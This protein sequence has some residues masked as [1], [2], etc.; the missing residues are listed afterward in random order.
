MRLCSPSLLGAVGG[1]LAGIL[2]QLGSGCS[3]ALVAPRYSSE[4][5]PVTVA[6]DGAGSKYKVL[7]LGL[8]LSRKISI[9]DEPH[10]PENVKVRNVCNV[11]TGRYRFCVL[12]D[13]TV[14]TVETLNGIPGADDE[15]AKVLKS[16]R[17]QPARSAVC[18][19][20][21]LDFDIPGRGKLCDQPKSVQRYWLDERR[22][23]SEVP[24]VPGL[25][26]PSSAVGKTLIYKFCVGKDGTV[27]S[28]IPIVGLA[29]ADIRIE[30]AI[31]RWRYSPLPFVACAFE[32]LKVKRDEF[33]I[34][35]I[36][37][38]LIMNREDAVPL[39]LNWDVPG[40][41]NS[42]NMLAAKRL[43]SEK[44]SGEDPHLPDAVRA[45]SSGSVVT[46]AYKLCVAMDGSI[47]GID[48]ASSIEGADEQIVATLSEWHYKAQPR[49]GCFIQFFEFE[50]I[51]N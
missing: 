43:C 11:L 28:A 16:W 35:S 50:I 34:P 14:D 25:A 42:P 22:L 31:K 37:P 13:G 33:G 15:I 2:L 44:V 21:S 10:L 41:N 12:P 24:R 5:G 46:G 7:P 36:A 30:E 6:S 3:P 1:V 9:D 49:P 8:L 26:L 23:S 32:L 45:R 40:M 51:S 19:V 47:G 38:A 17:F 29:T 48:V 20:Q 4:L 27:S 39:N 18:A